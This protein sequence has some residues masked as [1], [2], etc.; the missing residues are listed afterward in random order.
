MSVHAACS[1][2]PGEYSSLRTY[3]EKNGKCYYTYSCRLEPNLSLHFHTHISYRYIRRHTRKCYTTSTFLYVVQCATDTAFFPIINSI[4][5]RGFDTK[6][7]LNTEVHGTRTRSMQSGSS[8]RPTDVCTRVHNTWQHSRCADLPQGRR[9]QPPQGEYDTVRK[10]D[11][12]GKY[13]IYSPYISYPIHTH[14]RYEY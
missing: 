7:E 14:H 3:P 13:R 6:L 5:L 2:Q 8:K 1:R 9:D 10:Y 12:E 11:R 4:R